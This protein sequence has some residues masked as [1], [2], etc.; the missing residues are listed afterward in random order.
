MVFCRFGLVSCQA[1]DNDS[2]I[3]MQI[4]GFEFILKSLIGGTTNGNHISGFQ[5]C[6]SNITQYRCTNQEFH[7]LGFLWTV[8][9][10]CLSEEAK[11]EEA[12]SVGYRGGSHLLGRLIRKV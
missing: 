7:C 6:R 8:F 1:L 9:R 3:V 11:S 12:K 4:L 2:L 5:P 10:S